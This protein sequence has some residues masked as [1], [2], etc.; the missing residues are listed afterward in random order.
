MITVNYFGNI[1]EATQSN[2]ET[3]NHNSMSLAELL[4]LLNSKYAIAQF[5]FQVAVNRKIVSK[6]QALNIFDS[7]EIALLPPFAGG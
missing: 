5:P 4:D 3:L 1:A 7:D 2:S 6:Q